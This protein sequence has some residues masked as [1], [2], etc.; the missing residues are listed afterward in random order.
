MADG[1][2]HRA[3]TNDADDQTD[4]LAHDEDERDSE[5]ADARREAVH[6]R[7]ADELRDGVERERQV[8]LWD[9][10]PHGERARVGRLVN[11]NEGV[12]DKYWQFWECVRG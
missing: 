4:G 5:R 12:D 6:A 8:Y 10:E 2:S 1:M 7:G 11:R 9:G 3:G